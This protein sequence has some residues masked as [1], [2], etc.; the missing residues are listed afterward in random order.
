MAAILRSGRRGREVDSPRTPLLAGATH[1]G[2]AA[3]TGSDGRLTVH[4]DGP[5]AQLAAWVSSGRGFDPPEAL[6]LP[7][8]ALVAQLAALRSY[9][10]VVG[11]RAPRG[12]PFG[13]GGSIEADGWWPSGLRRWFRHQ[14]FR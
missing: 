6:V 7:K 3:D 4:R 5:L 2:R 14:L 8:R 1:G 11:V 10:P 12:S 13:A 9:E